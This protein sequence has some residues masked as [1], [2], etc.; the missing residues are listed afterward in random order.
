MLMSSD[1]QLMGHVF[2]CGAMYDTADMVYVRSSSS[3]FQYML[4]K[5]TKI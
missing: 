1:E 2:V 4:Y 3:W 5:Q